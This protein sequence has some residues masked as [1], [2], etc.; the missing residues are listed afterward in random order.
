MIVEIYGMKGCSYCESAIE[1]AEEYALPYFYK[2]LNK[3]Y[4]IEEFQLKFKDAVTFP[5]ITINGIPIGG[6][7]DFEE[8]MEMASE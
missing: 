6:Y 8:V 4:R 3:D 5:Q 1:L 2:E 7:S